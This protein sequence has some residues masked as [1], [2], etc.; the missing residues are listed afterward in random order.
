M[1]EKIKIENLIDFIHVLV[2]FVR[3]LIIKSSQDIDN[4]FYMSLTIYKFIVVMSCSHKCKAFNFLND[5][6]FSVLKKRI[7]CALIFSF[8]D[9]KEIVIFAQYLLNL[10]SQ[11]ITDVKSIS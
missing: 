2:D 8:S 5:V 7:S 4:K 11:F 9:I 10:K 6:Q 3:L 1:T